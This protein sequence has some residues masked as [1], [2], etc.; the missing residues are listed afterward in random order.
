[1][2]YLDKI[3]K[4]FCVSFGAWRTRQKFDYL[5]PAQEIA[6]LALAQD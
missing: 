4:N 1:M 2:M 5:F 3:E 6:A